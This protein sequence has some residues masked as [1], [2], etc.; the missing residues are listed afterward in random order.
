MSPQGT[1]GEQLE[2]ILYLLPLASREGG[3]SLTEAAERLGVSVETVQRDIE[4]VTARAY[5]HPAGGADEIQ[6]L[7]ETDRLKIYSYMKFNRP[8]K[9]SGREALSLA[10]GLRAAA[11][12]ASADRAAEI[13]DL[14]HRMEIELAVAS[15]GGDE[16]WFEIDEGDDEGAALRA[17]LK[18]AVKSRARCR[19]RYLKPDDAEPGEREVDP[20]A[21]VYGSGK[22]Y[23]IGHCHLR[24]DIR[25]FR[26]DRLLEASL[27]DASYDVPADFDPSEYVTAGRVFRTDAEDQV[28]VRYSARVAPWVREHGPVRELEDGRVSVSFTA[29]DP[30]WLVRHALGYGPEAEVVEPVAVRDMVVGAALAVC[31]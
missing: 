22:W 27:V 30:A 3:V 12:D 24:D 14:A 6:I 23:V 21:L 17:R 13:R 20:Y 7:L 18:Q 10:I 4:E 19:I 15:S 1:A 5:Y 2:R 26:V 31:R 16:D 11:N 9:L 28:V 29:A 8:P 25:A